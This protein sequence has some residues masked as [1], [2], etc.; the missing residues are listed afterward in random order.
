MSEKVV[1]ARSIAIVYDKDGVERT[2][3]VDP[4]QKVEDVPGETKPPTTTVS[5]GHKGEGTRIIT[6]K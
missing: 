1:P 6:R 2:I 5:G 4:G 3:A